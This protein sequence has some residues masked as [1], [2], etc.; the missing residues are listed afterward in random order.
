M[1]FIAQAARDVMI[2]CRYNNLSDQVAGDGWAGVEVR[3]IV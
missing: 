2:A 3:Q 1:N